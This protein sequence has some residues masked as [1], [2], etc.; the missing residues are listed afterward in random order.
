MAVAKNLPDRWVWVCDA[1]FGF[2]I[3]LG[4]QKL[5]ETLAS[6]HGVSNVLLQL[7]V[8]VGF[9]A[10]V[11]YDIGVYHLLIQ[12]R[13]YR[14]TWWSAARYMLDLVMSFCL[15]VSLLRGLSKQPEADGAMLLLAVTG[16]HL[17]AMLW[18]VFA[19]LEARQPIR[20]LPRLGPHLLF[21]AIYW[22]TALAV[23]VIRQQSFPFATCRL[24]EFVV[25]LS[26]ELLLVS[27]FR[28]FQL[29][30]HLA[31]AEL[32]EVSNPPQASLAENPLS[33]TTT[34]TTTQAE[35]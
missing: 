8:A 34:T 2:I 3:T 5:D 11:V 7:S 32:D 14:L 6:T 4:F 23:S 28:S 29:V 24:R 26:V 17:S 27:V 35:A 13:P 30:K 21:V 1:I 33:T 10:F 20:L 16:W 31:D 15:L 18:H 25:A 12:D 9:I 22:L 19:E